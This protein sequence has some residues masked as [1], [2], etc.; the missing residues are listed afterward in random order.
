V[1]SRAAYEQAADCSRGF[2]RNVVKRLKRSHPQQA[3]ALKG[4]APSLPRLLFNDSLML[5]R[6]GAEVTLEPIAGAAPGSS[7]VRPK[8]V[9]VAFLGDTLV[10]DRPPVMDQCPDT[11]AWLDTLT[12]LRRPHLSNI[13]FVPGRGPVG[14]QSATE[15]LSEYI[16][17]ARRRMRSLHRSEESRDNVADFVDELLS[18]FPLSE[19]E[20][21]QYR[22]RARNG[23]KRVYD[24]LSS[25]QDGG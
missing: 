9:E 8:D 7:Y 5:H 4:I 21:T 20:R 19:E 1:A 25:N 6:G 24:E 13:A 11:K 22:R 2:W 16:R 12:W 14:D 3:D 15:P 18:V 17:L 23:L 10:Y